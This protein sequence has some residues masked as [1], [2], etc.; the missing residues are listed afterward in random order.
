M[1]LA[2]QNL[3]KIK[4]EIG[5]LTALLHQLNNPDASDYLTTKPTLSAKEIAEMIADLF[6]AKKQQYNTPRNLNSIF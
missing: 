5:T 6:E 1:N 2:E 3:V 4:E